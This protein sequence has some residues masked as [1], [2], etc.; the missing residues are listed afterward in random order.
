MR[1]GASALLLEQ[2]RGPEQLLPAIAGTGSRSCS[3]RRRRTARCSTSC[4]ASRR[5][6]SLRRCVSAGENLPARHLAGLVRA[7]RPPADQRH[8]RDRAA[9]HLHLG[10][11]RGHQAR[12]DRRPGARVA[13]ARAGR[14]RRAGAGRR[15]PGC[16]R[17]AVR[18]AAAISP[19]RASA[20]YVRGGWNITGDTY[21]REPDG[22]FRYVARADDMIISAGYNIAGPEV[23][24][25]PAA[26]S[27]TS[28]RRPWWGGPTS[29]A[30]RS[31]WRTSCCGRASTRRDGGGAAR[32]RPGGAGAV[33][34]P[35]RDRLRRR[36]AAH[37]DRQAPA[38]PAA[39]RR[40]PRTPRSTSE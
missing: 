14:G 38:L 7:H 13:G 31:W 12:H 22:Y 40:R 19:T 20:T 24:E 37:A 23:E 16:S 26:P 35:A 28:P 29:G 32:V 39:R 21:V 11:R 5:L 9:A 25:R 8:R 17:C 36:A 4:D 34:V 15:R 6:G 3:R 2:W 27:R 30:G 18:S 33:Q 1:A 10:R